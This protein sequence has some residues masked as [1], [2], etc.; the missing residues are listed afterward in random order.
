ML[1]PPVPRLSKSARQL[2]KHGLTP[3]DVYALAAALV[4]RY[5][6]FDPVSRPPLAIGIHKAIIA[7]L[8]CHPAALN[9]ALGQWCGHSWYLR[10]FATATHRVHLDG[11]PATEV[12]AE[13]K[14]IA[15]HQRSMLVNR[16]SA[17]GSRP[18]RL[19]TISSP[20]VR[21]RNP[22]MAI[23]TA[24]SLKVTV[25]LD[26]ASVQT[27]AAPEGGAA[28][29]MLNVRL[30]DR[31][32]TVDLASKAIRKAQAVID[33]HGVDGTAVI[34]QGK[35]LA[36]DVLAECGILAQ[37][38]GKKPEAPTVVETAPVAA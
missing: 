8:D 29:T 23:V 34:L 21:E 33:E 4:E 6:A 35:L 26:P 31:T 38:K 15:A 37:P 16:V 22:A 18:A 27:I 32:L 17:S 13:E 24:K 1:D 3:H 36:G 5:P 30:P 7:D 28:R 20:H 9:H 11:S 2:A 25:V 10:S 14:A 12:T 19:L